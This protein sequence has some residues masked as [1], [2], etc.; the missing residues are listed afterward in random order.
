[1]LPYPL[2]TVIISKRYFFFFEVVDKLLLSFSSVKVEGPPLVWCESDS[3]FKQ[4]CEEKTD[5]FAIFS[6]NF[7]SYEKVTYKELYG[8]F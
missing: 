2:C 4:L 5:V 7:M 6:H 1:M 3:I 8:P